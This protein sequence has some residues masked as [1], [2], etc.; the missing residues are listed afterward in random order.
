MEP[1]GSSPHSQA[2]ATSSNPEPAQSSPH[3]HIPLFEDPRMSIDTKFLIY[4]SDLI[5]I[6]S[7][8]WFYNF[9]LLQDLTPVQKL[10]C[11]YYL[12]SIRKA[13]IDWHCNVKFQY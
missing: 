5:D 11:C 6:E 2:P 3:T 8:Y 1:E 12:C 10:I 9:L 7:L 4:M 13:Y